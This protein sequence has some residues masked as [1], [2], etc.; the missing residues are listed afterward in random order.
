MFR[1][2]GLNVVDYFRF[3]AGSD[4]ASAS[5]HQIVSL[6]TPRVGIPP[7]RDPVLLELGS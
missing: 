4:M 6:P 2:E 5:A 1:G 7:F 3:L